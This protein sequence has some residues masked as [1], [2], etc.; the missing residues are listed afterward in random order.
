MI[1][2]TNTQF[3]ATVNPF[4]AEL[5]TLTRRQDGREYIWSDTT[6]KYWGRHAPILFPA[7]GRSNDDQYVVDGRTYPMHQH[8]FARDFEFT[9]VT[10]SRD[11]TVTLTLHDNAETR[12]LYPFAFALT[13][14][15][16]LTVT[17][18]AVHYTVANTSAQPLPF[19]LGSHPG[20]ALSQPLDQYVVTLTGAKLPLTKFGIGPVPFRNGKVEPLTAADGASLPLSHELLDDGLLII[21]APDA[22][23][24]T[25]ASK[26]GSYKVTLSLADFPYLTLWS[27]EHKHAPFVCV[28]PFHG[29]PD[30][31]GQPT[32]WYQKPGNTTVA[33]G[34]RVTLATP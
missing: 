15:Y 19:A 14:T 9:D 12:K 23:S 20:F 11:D 17:G 25:L 33:P 34:G 18:L 1:T 24:A 6:G 29:L 28:E 7:I 27:P 22:T 26:D 5:T 32:D 2:L 30:V 21:N 31:S 4:G 3:T 13:V 10:Q 8:G 16:T